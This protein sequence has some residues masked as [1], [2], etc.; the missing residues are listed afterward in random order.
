MTKCWTPPLQTPPDPWDDAA[1]SR[2]GDRRDNGDWEASSTAP[3][4]TP[5]ASAVVEP[6]AWLWEHRI[7]LGALTLLDGHPDTGKSTITLDL[8]ARL[9]GGR[10]MP[11]G[12]RGIDGATLLLSTEDTLARPVRERLEAAGAN[13]DRVYGLEVKDEREP[14]GRPATF[15][16]DVRILHEAIMHTDAKLVVIDPIM[17]HLSAVLSANADQ[18]VRRALTPLVRVAT[19][20]GAAI[21]MVRHLRKPERGSKAK[22]TWLDG[23]GSSGGFGIVRAGLVATRDPDDDSICTLSQ[24]KHNYGELVRAVDY[25][26]EKVPGTTVSRIRWLPR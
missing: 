17:A 14:F 13:L 15:P 18:E 8:A 4:I 24:T 9:S 23:G 25:T 12:S 2:F 22:P 3:I 16:E 6:I 20:T 1:W 10:R 26:F 19:A 7:P 11:D 5:A 21:V